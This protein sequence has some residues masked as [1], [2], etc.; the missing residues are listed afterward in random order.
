MTPASPRVGLY[1]SDGRQDP[2][3]GK[4]WIGEAQR[5]ALLDAIKVEADKYAPPKAVIATKNATV[6]DRTRLEAK[7]AR[8]VDALA[9]G[10]LTKA[11]ATQ[12]IAQV[13]EELSVNA[14]K[15]SSLES[16][17]IPSTGVDWSDPD[18]VGEQL[19]TMFVN[20]QLDRSYKHITVTWAVPDAY[21]DKAARQALE[22]EEAQAVAA[23]ESEAQA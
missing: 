3:H 13:D 7:R 5:A 15:E 6:K 22:A 2:S 23:Y 17:T 9:D 20:V 14:R 1:C 10:I 19:R 18:K 8:L 4:A 16:V 11:E 12:R 21:H